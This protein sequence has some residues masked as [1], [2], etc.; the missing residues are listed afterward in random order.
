MIFASA[1][2]E[3]DTV[4][5]ALGGGAADYLVKPFSPT[6]LAA[7]VGLAL[8]RH[9][10]SSANATSATAYPSPTGHEGA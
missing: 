10:A 2:G 4:V 8:R 7:R 6:D 1:Y 3:G 9:A 5:R